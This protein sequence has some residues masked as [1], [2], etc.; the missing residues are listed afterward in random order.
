M[1]MPVAKYF[2]KLLVKPGRRTLLAHTA[3][4]YEY[5]YA[6]QGLGWELYRTS[7]LTRLSRIRPILGLD[8]SIATGRRYR[9]EY[10][11]AS[12]S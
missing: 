5:E 12:Y 3:L 2:Y 10:S 7:V 8:R 4:R 11:R 1:S 9:M 6:F